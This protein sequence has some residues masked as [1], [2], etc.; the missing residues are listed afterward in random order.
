MLSR[1]NCR[2]GKNASLNSVFYNLSTCFLFLKLKGLWSVMVT[3]LM[4]KGKQGKNEIH[5]LE[6]SPSY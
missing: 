6:F 4:K 2:K 1:F 5:M 3:T